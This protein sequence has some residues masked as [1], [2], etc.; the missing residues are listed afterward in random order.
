MAP[1]SRAPRRPSRTAIFLAYVKNQNK[2][3][4][5]AAGPCRHQNIAT[6]TQFRHWGSCSRCR[7]HTL[8]QLRALLLRAGVEPNP[9]PH[10]PEDQRIY[11]AE[12]E[13]LSMPAAARTHACFAHSQKGCAN[14]SCGF[15]H[16]GAP[17]S[18]VS[19]EAALNSRA[20]LQF[21]IAHDSSKSTTR[22]TAATTPTTAVKHRR[23]GAGGIRTPPPHQ[24]DRPQ[25][26]PHLGPRASS[27]KPY[28]DVIRAPKRTKFD[29]RPATTLHAGVDIST[30]EALWFAAAA[31]ALR[32][33]G[34]LAAQ[35]AAAA[36]AKGDGVK[37]FFARLE[38]TSHPGD[39]DDDEQPVND[40]P[41]SDFHPSAYTPTEPGGAG[42]TFSPR[43]ATFDRW[44]CPWPTCWRS[45][46]T[47]LQLR[48]H[49]KGTHGEWLTGGGA[50][51]RCVGI[52]NVTGSACSLQVAV[53]LL[54]I[55][56]ARPVPPQVAASGR[57]APIDALSQALLG[58]TAGSAWKLAD[59]LMRQSPGYD[60]YKPAGLRDTLRRL[61]AQYPQVV[62][63]AGCTTAMLCS[64][65]PLKLWHST[66]I[67]VPREFRLEHIRDLQCAGVEGGSQV[68]CGT[69]GGAAQLAMFH[70]ARTEGQ[71]VVGSPLSDTAGFAVFNPAGFDAAPTPS[72][73]MIGACAY[74][75]AGFVVEAPGHVSLVKAFQKRAADIPA[76]FAAIDGGAAIR[77]WTGLRR[78][79]KIIAVAFSREPPPPPPEDNYH[80][81]A[82]PPVVVPPRPFL[83][84][85]LDPTAI[86]EE[87]LVGR[88]P[89]PIEGV[90]IFNCRGGAASSTL[91]HVVQLAQ[92][93]DAVLIAEA[94]GL[95]PTRLA[96]L[97][98][99]CCI[100]PRPRGPGGGAA[101]VSRYPLEEPAAL[102]QGGAEI[103]VASC[104]GVRLAA[105]YASCALPIDFELVVAPLGDCAVVG[106]D[107]NAESPL[108][109][110]HCPAPDA[111]R[112]RKGR[113][114]EAWAVARGLGAR[115][116]ATRARSGSPAHI[117]IC[118]FD[119]HT[120]GIA[121]E[122]K[123]YEIPAAV[124]DHDAFA[125]SF[126]GENC[127]RH[128]TR[129]I[130]AVSRRLCSDPKAAAK[131][132]RRVERLL[133]NYCGG[134]SAGATKQLW[135]IT[136]A[137]DEAA[138][139]EL[140]LR[141]PFRPPP[142]ER[143][144]P[145]I[146]KQAYYAPFAALGRLRDPG[147]LDG[148]GVL[149]DDTGTQHRGMAAAE[150]VAESFAEKHAL[151]EELDP[152]FHDNVSTVPPP[153]AVGDAEV[154]AALRRVKGGQWSSVGYVS[155]SLLRLAM[156]RRFTRRFIA[157][158]V[159]RCL[160]GDRPA[161]W[162]LST[163]RPLQK[164]GKPT[165]LIASLRPV[166]C[167]P[168]V[169]SLVERV[170]QRRYTDRYATLLDD[171]QAGFR[172]GRADDLASCALVDFIL[173][174]RSRQSRQTV[175]AR[176][177]RH[178]R[179]LLLAID[180]ADAFPRLDPG[181]LGREL[182]RRDDPLIH[183][184]W[185]TTST[186]SIRVRLGKHVSTEK[187]TPA[188]TTTGT[189]DAP[190]MWT[191][192]MDT[193]L[194]QL[195]AAGDSRR[196]A[197]VE[198]LHV[199]V[200]DDLTIA[201]SGPTIESIAA[202]A[203][204]LLGVVSRW[205]AASNAA[206][207]PKSSALLVRPFAANQHL[208]DQKQWRLSTGQE[209]P[210]LVCGGV[211]IPVAEGHDTIRV[212]GVQWDGFAR[213]DSHLRLMKRKA[214]RYMEYVTL[215]GAALPPWQARRIYAALPL[216]SLR[217]HL[218]ALRAAPDFDVLALEALERYHEGCCRQ[219]LGAVANAHAAACV[220]E[221]GFTSLAA[222]A[223]AAALKRQCLW[224]DLEGDLGHRARR[225]L[226][227]AVRKL[228]NAEVPP[229]S[230]HSAMP[231]E[232]PLSHDEVA[233]FDAVEGVRFETSAAEARPTSDEAKRK[234]NAVALAR[235][236]PVAVRCWTDGSHQPANEAA[237][238]DERASSAFVVRSGDSLVREYSV[239]VGVPACSFSAEVEAIVLLLTWLL[240]QPIRGAVAILTDSLSTIRAL[241]CG[242]LT[243]R[244]PRLRHIW[245]ALLRA[246][247]QGVHVTFCFQYSHVGDPDAD[248]VDSLAKA[249]LSQA[250]Q[251]PPW[252]YD[253]VTQ[254]MRAFVATAVAR[255]CHGTFRSQ[256]TSAPTIWR[257]AEWRGIPSTAARLIAQMR[258]GNSAA[259]GG[260]LYRQTDACPHC[261]APLVR[262]AGQ[263]IAH[264]F[265]CPHDACAA[266]RDA[267][268]PP[269][270]AVDLWQRPR[271]ALEYLRHYLP[272][273]RWPS[274]SRS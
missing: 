68:R 92:L 205:C 91:R 140:G 174:A 166:A 144:V 172:P 134:P 149:A 49:C 76:S 142:V 250:A 245:R 274:S 243:Q 216:A 110:P 66:M 65:T 238:I 219:L 102:H 50:D 79:E 106:G 223:L 77:P 222:T 28:A 63:P 15:R 146:A 165:G 1:R 108:W 132:S 272:P 242:P 117:D 84:S 175:G 187:S 74:H 247:A 8:A 124:S 86:G 237:H 178:H 181:E 236:G 264:V 32:Y 198:V 62:A 268:Q 21:T 203:R 130:V 53:E 2:S 82:A 225:V 56:G 70:E 19:R 235:L 182:L 230:L 33:L 159:T 256:F 224:R 122:G 186:K 60:P 154:D 226:A 260:H 29:P 112:W 85:P 67:V 6:C 270:S 43:H 271:Q 137:V 210:P 169:R 183:W 40:C 185:R 253:C 255:D 241:Q 240:A 105:V 3:I 189:A 125:V 152:A 59:D 34:D 22:P 161:V 228:S 160:Q 75:T 207:S 11:I 100:A 57:A 97:G 267:L 37:A 150:A 45:F 16:Y 173:Q 156:T 215:L 61:E 206:V 218:H 171:A 94:H 273:N 54:R 89:R 44:L 98:L 126:E 87:Q 58:V 266:A 231:P 258:T 141:G 13:A 48:D 269:I 23:P 153:S 73:L 244:I 30:P 17:G 252:A 78:G 107:F 12:A 158:L 14:M 192:F 208:A 99:H 9:G 55:V 201:V 220:A 4:G 221:A 194:R 129:R 227:V 214:A 133:R 20:A 69:C 246:T 139:S 233:G 26:Q 47:P 109:S 116:C 38:M 113:V 262:G 27:A 184:A 25:E 52:P 204:T 138:R 251:T 115:A 64:C 179:V 265:A 72:P 157:N 170:W 103:A 217:H 254:T 248:Y 123:L 213:F 193:L 168:T 180:L 83:L 147:T 51:G 31:N 155:S 145:D 167:M 263:P 41:H 101:I 239:G 234:L 148:S 143:V 71:G 197:G 209:V 5:P 93:H 135:A 249:G 202:A 121:S 111:R 196:I 96:D 257:A 39:D 232:A 119:P 212:L 42:V 90:C 95:A 35:A 127:P 261:D 188:G 259:V 114:L 131:Y 120:V 118:F 176:A 7:W 164:P 162:H 211:P 191:T 24:A 104:R 88:A 199:A 36:A 46:A 81:V 128:S 151:R 136:K 200:A 80:A 10:R 177:V 18:R 229:D 190:G 195:R 163:I